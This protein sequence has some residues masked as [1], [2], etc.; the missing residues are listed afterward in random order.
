[1]AAVY[2]G[3]GTN[4]G[5]K[6]KNITNATILLGSVMGEIKNLSSLYETEPWGFESDNSFLN[7]VVLLE[8]THSPKVCLEMAKAIEREMGRTYTKSGYEDRIIDVDILMYDSEVVEEEN[9]IIPHALLHKRDFVLKPMAELAPDLCHPV[10]GK[11]ME[12]LLSDL[13]KND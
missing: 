10:L 12:E 3:L 5:D 4:L 6:K 8:T 2:I 9:L 13:K 1:M 7:A 11:S